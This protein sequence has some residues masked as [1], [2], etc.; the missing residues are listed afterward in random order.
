MR[1]T[2]VRAA[3]ETHE[4]QEPSRLQALGTR[5]LGA[6]LAAALAVATLALA[7]TGRLTLYISPETVWF[8]VAAAIATLIG[9][10]WSCALPLG[11]EQE[12]GH[13]HGDAGAGHDHADEHAHPR[14]ARRVVG[15]VAGATGGVI[16]TGVVA[17]ALLLPPASL[18][19]DMA[20]Q[21][22]PMGNVLFAGADNVALGA[23][24]DTS[25]FGIGGWA[26][27]FATGSRPEK[28]DGSSVTLTGFLTPSG[29]AKDQAHLTRMVISHCVLD[30]QP[31][32]VPVQITG[33]QGQYAV[34]DWIQV[35]GTVRASAD[36]KLSI[37]PA[38]VSKIPEPKDPYEH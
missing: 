17:G 23:N 27:V 38:S 22:A 32:S 34:G 33:W 26:S 25:T 3:S 35:K 21:R 7:A 28:Y 31:A 9:V 12:H 1:D 37:V 6:G 24:T 4:G 2:T 15:V 30:A 18:S 11:A 10:V 19:V 16:A 36:G 5:W 29:S 13:E 8:A 14:P 20:M